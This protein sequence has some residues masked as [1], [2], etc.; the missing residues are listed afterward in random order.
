MPKLGSNKTKL[1][2]WVDKNLIAEAR[3]MGINISSFLELKLG[4]YIALRKG[5]ATA[6]P[7]SP[8]RIRTGVAGSRVR[9]D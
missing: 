3:A 9:Q 4:E 5:E 6:L 2:L 1:T 8:G 7:N